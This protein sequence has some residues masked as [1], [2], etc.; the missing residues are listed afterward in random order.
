MFLL[1]VLIV[2]ICVGSFLNVLI[3]R[4][5]NNE[6]PLKGRSYCDKCRRTL[7]WYDLIP[8]L[9]YIVLKGKCRYCRKKISASYPIVEAITGVLFVATYLLMASF[10]PTISSFEFFINYFYYLLIVCSLIVVFFADIKYGIIPDG[11]IY[12]SIGISLLYLLFNFDKLAPG[13][14]AG[15]VSLAFFFFLHLVTKGRGMG[16]GDVKLSL[17]LGLFLGPVGTAI[18]L[19]IAFLTGAVVGLILIIWRKKKLSTGTIPFG[20]F[21]A[22]GAL[23]NLFFGEKILQMVSP[24]LSFW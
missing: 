17:F 12:P 2:G 19:Y 8:L 4:L 15:A 16:F 6:N 13:L 1:L 18:S 14:I 5:P 10:H 24:W 22:A 11:V 23:I 20:P 21:M 7:E 3:D 9:S